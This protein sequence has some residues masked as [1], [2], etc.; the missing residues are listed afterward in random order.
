MNS[1]FT[2]EAST[3]RRTL[4]SNT[5]AS[6]ASTIVAV[7]EGRGAASEI[8]IASIDIDRTVCSV[9]QI[10]DTCAYSRTLTML[11]VCNP[12]VILF[13]EQEAQTTSKLQ[14]ALSESYEKGSLAAWPR[15]SFND[16]T[17]MKL[18]GDLCLPELIPALE[19]TIF[20]RGAFALA[21][22]AALFDY[23][24][25]TQGLMFATG[26]VYFQP[27]RVE[28][29]MAIDHAAAK[30]LEL[31]RNKRNQKS[32]QNLLGA[33]SH[34]KTRMGRRMLRMSIL[35][36]LGD[37]NMITIRQA[38]VQTLLQSEK[39]FE[40]LQDALA[41]LPD[42]D[43][44]IS[45]LVQIP[46]IESSREAERRIQVLVGLKQAI[47]IMRSLN[48][49]I[50]P[51]EH[52][53]FKHLEGIFEGT[54]GLESLLEGVIEDDAPLAKGAATQQ[55]RAHAIKMSSNSLLEV[56]RKTLK[57]TID[58]IYEYSN[59]L[60]T[61][62]D[63]ALQVK[64]RSPRGFFLTLKKSNLSGRPFPDIF[65]NV[66]GTN[67]LAFSTLDL[68]KLNERV[69]ESFAEIFLMSDQVALETVSAIRNGFLSVLYK[70]SEGI[71][72]LDLLASFAE[73]A[74]LNN[75]V[76]PV[77]SEDT[78]AIRQGRHPILDHLSKGTVVGNDILACPGHT[79]LVITGPNM[80]G[81]STYMTQ[82]ALLTIMAHMGMFI[83]AK[84]ATTRI[85]DAI[86]TRIGSDDDMESNASTFLVEMNELAVTLQNMTSRSMLVI[87][88]LGKGTSTMDG[89]CIT[90]AVCE[91]LI[92]SACICLLATH[93][94]QLVQYLAV[95]PSVAV[96]NL[97][98]ERDPEGRFA[99]AYT[100]QRGFSP[101]EDYGL[102]LAAQS[103]FNG[104]AL[105][106]AQR[107]SELIKRQTGQSAHMLTLRKVLSK[108]KLCAEIAN[109]ARKLLEKSS[110]TDKD[111]TGCLGEI[112][113]E[114][115]QK[116]DSI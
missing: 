2:F 8:G 84:A 64:F 65:C 72:T 97:H 46:K 77:L 47:R 25:K 98:V 12:M 3:S 10:A 105:G 70:A 29:I 24:E 27:H 41:M 43:S 92:R 36:P 104:Q 14:L 44:L 32:N 5:A 40:V 37:A 33:I 20:K 63:L 116:L 59:A 89:L 94:A 86:Y 69:N 35:Q 73:Y 111:L 88:E 34:T 26:S 78:L 58:D 21:A 113:A 115:A 90:T 30:S 106:V 67:V 107:T 91:S 16:T 66:S 75:A 4:P 93:F 52:Q 80:S 87:D 13:S 99:C 54:R 62:F 110:L 6:S 85:F 31:V 102:Q 81:K 57:E 68:L 76:C 114:L 53:L 95:L 18:I 28:G 1:P 38:C 103:G 74:A 22:V 109:K 42:T 56:A 83:P 51:L 82:I 60:A 15:R 71:A 17:G 108:K 49:L 48:E 45:G 101:L 9:C 61:H 100:L 96:M 112:R 39:T 55:Q 19:G 50:S 23:C 79:F 7:A 11:H